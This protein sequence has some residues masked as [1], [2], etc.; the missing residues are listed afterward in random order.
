MTTVN[1]ILW[2]RYQNYEG[3]FFPGKI[4]YSLPDNADFRDKLIRV[5]TATE[6]GTYD[7]VNMYDSCILTV[8]VIQ[9]C[10][11]LGLV[12]SML[13][14]CY[15]TDSELLK[16]LLSEF[17]VPLELRQ[18]GQKWNLG[19]IN[20]ES[21]SNADSMKRI[22]FG[23]S[24]G[25]KG[26]W[27]DSQKAYAKGIAAAF[28]NLWE[29]ESLRI[30]QN[31]Y[32][33]NRIMSFIVDRSK[34]I[35]FQSSVETGYEAATKAMFMSYSLNNPAKADS[36]LFSATQDSGWSTNDWTVKFEI[37]SR[38][39]IYDSGI[40]I[41]P[42]RYIKIKPVIEKLFNVSLPTLEQIANG[43]HDHDVSPQNLA[44]TEDVQ[45]ALLKLGYD[46]GPKG[47]D[48]IL[49]EKTKGATIAFQCSSGIKPTGLI[50][51]QTKTAL[52]NAIAKL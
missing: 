36:G 11:K 28:S 12:S 51:I 25:T 13:G 18:S 2:S 37:A 40:A 5:V 9:L 47:A 19:V 15:K 39:I 42:G 10:E 24:S 6:G 31:R 41:W 44:T 14:E 8:G 20:G 45:K 35:L 16:K 26:G 33:K 3:P 43:V 34:K 23:G 17:P 48:G 7:A 22:Y 49:G 27:D 38:H 52:Q 21:L 4:R 46:L 1:E 30:G 50:D 32:M 29:N